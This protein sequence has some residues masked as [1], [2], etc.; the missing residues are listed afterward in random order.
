MIPSDTGTAVLSVH[1]NVFSSV[2]LVD[3]DEAFLKF[4][5]S[6]PEDGVSSAVVLD[7]KTAVAFIQSIGRI[8]NKGELL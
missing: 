5:M 7:Y 8:I 2:L 6:D 3:G 1:G 4:V